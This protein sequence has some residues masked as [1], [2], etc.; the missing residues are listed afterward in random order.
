MI[1]A[2]ND[3]PQYHMLIFC[4]HYYPPLA[5]S[6]SNSLRQLA[7]WPAAAQGHPRAGCVAAC[8][9]AHGLLIVF[10]QRGLFECWL[11]RQRYVDYDF[12]FTLFCRLLKP[13]RY[14]VYKFP[15]LLFWL[16]LGCVASIALADLL[17]V[18][19]QRGLFECCL[20]VGGMSIM[21]FSSLFFVDCWSH[22]SMSYTSF[23]IC[24]LIW[25]VCVCWHSGP[26]AGRPY[27]SCWFTDSGMSIL[28]FS[29]LFYIN[30]LQ[31]NAVCRI[32]HSSYV[33]LIWTDCVTLGGPSLV[34]AFFWK[35]G[36][37]WV[38]IFVLRYVDYIFS[39]QGA[40]VLDVV[41]IKLAEYDFLFLYFPLVDDM[42]MFA[43][44]AVFES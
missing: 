39:V 27:L 12:Q 22:C 36:P 37:F 42:S 11:N 20:K 8:A 14:V 21:I 35:G 23:H 17:I 5:A 34:L 16:G 33:L 29:F 31:H 7:Q 1:V 13:L 44:C 15:V 10:K 25:I 3:I 30:C 32:Q 43:R 9:L 18:F 26:V 28:I 4:L 24:V 2:I 41:R 19:K 6:V 38:A 40:L